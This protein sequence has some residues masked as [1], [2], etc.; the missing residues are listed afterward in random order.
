MKGDKELYLRRRLLKREARRRSRGSNGF[1]W[2]MRRREATW[3]R[4]RRREAACLSVG[5]GGK[6]L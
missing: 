4:M 5:I 1:V 2:R 6:D 3:R